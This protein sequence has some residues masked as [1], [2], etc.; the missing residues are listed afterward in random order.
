MS[1]EK[2]RQQYVA[3]KNEGTRLTAETSSFNRWV[4]WTTFESRNEIGYENDESAYGNRGALIGKEVATQYGQFSIGGKLDV[5]QIDFFLHHLFGASSITTANSCSTW[6]YSLLQN[7]QLP[8][9]TTQFERGAEGAKKLT[10]CS[11][12]TMELN[13]G[14]DDSNYLVSGHAVKEDAGNSLTSAYAAAARKLMGKH[15]TMYYASTLAGL[16]SVSSPTGTTFKVRS[17]KISIETGVDA[18]RYFELGSINPTD[19]TADGFKITIELEI[20]HSSANASATFQTNFDAGTAMAF[21]LHAVGS[22]YANIGTSSNKPTL[23]LAV[24]PSK[25]TLGNAIPLDDLITQTMTIEVEQPNL[26]V[27]TLIG[28]NATVNL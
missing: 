16:G 7:L 17:A 27:M 20:I 1:A 18:T 2:G 11:P 22:N 3:V 15:V 10:G 8:T 23:S 9:F 14:V 12:A 19:I 6:V 4:P 5:D 13:F 24:P 25:V 21:R 28:A 26:A